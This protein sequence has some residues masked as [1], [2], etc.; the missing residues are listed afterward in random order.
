[1]KKVP[2]MIPV[3]L[4]MLSAACGRNDSGGIPP[5]VISKDQ[6][7]LMTDAKSVFCIIDNLT[8]WEI[9]TGGAKAVASCTVGEKLALTGQTTVSEISGARREL[10]R[11]KTASGAE[12]WVRADSVAV[13]SVLGVITA[14]EAV[15]YSRPSVLRIPARALPRMTIVAIQKSSAG[16]D[17]LRVSCADPEKAGALRGIYLENTGVSSRLDDVKSAILF[18]LAARTENPKKKAAFLTSSLTDYPGSRFA[19]DIRQALAATQEPVSSDIPTEEYTASFVTIEDGINVL[20]APDETA[21][22]V[23][24]TIDRNKPVQS[25][26]KTRQSYTIGALS[27]PWYKLKDPEGWVFGVSL[28][29]K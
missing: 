5:I 24:A 28:A 21:G 23:V 3:L 2:V 19:P 27:A 16:T 4:I 18:I 26:E 7:E 8:V 11:V 17:F 25:T 22:T 12:G 6:K 15:M 29:P 9:A 1:M 20:S 13:D 10:F 14:D